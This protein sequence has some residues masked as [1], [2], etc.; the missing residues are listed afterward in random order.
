MFVYQ[1]PGV[2][3][4]SP[5]GHPG[6]TPESPRG[7]LGVTSGSPGDPGGITPGSLM[8]VVEAPRRARPKNGFK[9]MVVKRPQNRNE[10]I[11]TALFIKMCVFT[12]VSHYYVA[13]RQG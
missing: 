12:R 7:R 13:G 10:A 5:W 1:H 11:A 6:V 9:F 4:G 2:V 8:L 3:L